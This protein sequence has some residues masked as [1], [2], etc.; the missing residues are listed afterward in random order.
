VSARHACIPSDSGQV[1]FVPGNNELRL[2]KRD[3]KRFADSLEKCDA[4]LRVCEE[5]LTLLLLLIVPC[6]F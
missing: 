4:V 1:F 3:R 5:V 6:M 2:N